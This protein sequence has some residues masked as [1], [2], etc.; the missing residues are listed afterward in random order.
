MRSGVATTEQ[1]VQL[2]EEPEEDGERQAWPVERREAETLV[3]GLMELWG[4]PIETLSRAG[5][6]FEGLEAL[7]GG[8][9]S[10]TFD[11]QV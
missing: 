2:E 10:G 4:P 7:L 9:R 6:A 1:A 3:A 5:R 11:L 8:G